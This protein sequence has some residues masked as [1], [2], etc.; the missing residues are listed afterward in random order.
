M[1]AA[2]YWYANALSAL[3]RTDEASAAWERAA[4]LDHI[5]AKR[6][7]SSANLVDKQDDIGIAYYEAWLQDF[8]YPDSSWVRELVTGARDPVTVLA[9]LD[10]RI[11]QILASVPAENA[12]G[13]Q[14]LMVNLYLELGYLDR[15]FEE[16]FGIALDSGWG[17]AA[18]G[19]WFGT[20]FRRSGFTAHPKYLEAAE[21]NGFIELWEQRGAPDFCEKVDDDWVC[22]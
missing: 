18:T 6:F 13:M 14:N 8:G 20:I 9:Y 19:I 11:P 2:N 12:S 15:Y 3:G 1:P 16:L 21:A 7:I 10:R 22:Q 5:F 17:D 4:Q